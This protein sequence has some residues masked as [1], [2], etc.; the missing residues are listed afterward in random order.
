MTV[1]LPDPVGPS[2]RNS[3]PCA[4]RAEVDG[5]PA[6]ERTDGLQRQ[7]AQLHQALFST[8]TSATSSYARAQHGHLG[9]ASGRGR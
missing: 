2:S 1:D 5:V 9:R 3:P 4:E 6:G 7:G 8:S